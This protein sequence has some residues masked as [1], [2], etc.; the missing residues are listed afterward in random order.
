MGPPNNG[1]GVMSWEFDNEK[2]LGEKTVTVSEVKNVGQLAGN[3]V[4]S[5][6]G[7][8]D[9][10]K[11]DGN[12]KPFQP[13]KPSLL[14][15][16]GKFISTA[17]SLYAISPGPFSG[18]TG[19]GGSIL[20]SMLTALDGAISKESKDAEKFFQNNE[21]VLNF[22][23]T[24]CTFSNLNKRYLDII[25]KQD[26]RPLAI[27]TAT[28]VAKEI[29][30]IKKSNLDCEECQT[31]KF[32]T[33]TS[34][35]SNTIFD[36]I[37][38]TLKDN[39]STWS[40]KCNAIKALLGGKKQDQSTDLKAIHTAYNEWI[41]DTNHKI[42]ENDQAT[43]ED[44]YQGLLVLSDNDNL[45]CGVLGD[46]GD[47]NTALAKITNAFDTYRKGMNQVIDEVSKANEETYNAKVNNDKFDYASREANIKTAL[48]AIDPW[49][50]D[51]KR[52]LIA[53][54]NDPAISKAKAS[55][56]IAQ[57]IKL[58]SAELEDT[59]KF[60][61]SPTQTTISAGE[62]LCLEDRLETMA[63][64]YLNRL[65]GSASAGNG[66]V[67]G[68]TKVI[69]GR[70]ANNAL[71]QNAQNRHATGQTQFDKGTQALQ[72]FCNYIIKHH[73]MLA[74]PSRINITNPYGKTNTYLKCEKL[75]PNGWPDNVPLE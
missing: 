73:I 12:C 31:K 3:M 44:A 35:L 58:K 11:T 26:D 47:F 33:A 45:K 22:G 18:L 8:I 60:D 40:V 72:D 37:A 14:F 51:N 10:L 9:A 6:G 36:K 42:S 20:G 30:T 13:R 25:R 38:N 48:A 28:A 1:L 68:N 32:K 52:S 16:L 61:W 66:E 57:A 17:S 2:K 54:L 62:Q 53:Q 39:D 69:N 49:P 74:R 29:E 15:S 64:V 4:T 43:I 21:N 63:L 75:M 67:K 50:T 56:I 71:K 34:P 46:E 70:K 41:K 5:I 24:I 19:I 23:N 27:Q 65:D 59:L 7:V 55:E